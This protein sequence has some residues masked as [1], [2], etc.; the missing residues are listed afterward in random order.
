MYVTCANIF[1]SLIFLN[2]FLRYV[3]YWIIRKLSIDL[4]EHDVQR[5]NNG[6]YVGEEVLRPDVLQTRQMRKARRFDLASIRLATAVADEINAEFAFRRLDGG[7]RRSWRHL[8]TLGVQFEVMN[9]RLHASL[10][11]LA[12][13][14]HDLGIVASYFSFGHLIQTL[15][16]DT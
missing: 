3:N 5:A 12:S 10:H 9:K 14:G 1:I 15:V 16:D 6:D 7:V 11:L 4:A 2:L 8:E 13:R